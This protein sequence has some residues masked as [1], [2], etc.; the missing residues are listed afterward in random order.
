MTQ[1]KGD[2]WFFYPTQ[3]EYGH[4]DEFGLSFDSV[5]FESEG[6]LLHG[7]Y[8][9]SE[10]RAKGTV[11]HCH[12][13]AGNISGHFKYVTWMPKRG[14]NV[15]CFDYRGFG[16]SQ[17]TPT[18]PGA[19]AD[20]H[21]AVDYLMTRSDVD[22]TRIA[23]FGQSLGGAVGIVAAAQRNDL[24]AVAIEGA[25]SS[26]RRAARFAC[27]NTWFL[28]G[29]AL[30]LPQLLIEA[31]IDPIEHVADISPTPTLFVTGTKDR[32]CDPKQLIALYEKAGAT[33]SI[34]VIEGGGHVGAMTQTEGM[35]ADRFDDFLT[36]C[37]AGFDTRHQDTEQF[38][39]EIRH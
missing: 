23:L 20:T 21:A 26:Y 36:Q 34:W 17:G 13:N 30:W 1:L 5:H 16:R 38:V 12:G 14:W 27:K 7:W 8:F 4:P 9:P 6:N 29:A 24:C 22:P 19:V 10:G 32:V 37:V 35:G 3:T 33:K 11:V 31:G 39:T 18:R 2:R 25:F 28:W 15:F